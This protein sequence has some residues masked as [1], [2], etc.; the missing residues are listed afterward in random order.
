MDI[1][2][3]HLECKRMNNFVILL[4][5]SYPFYSNTSQIEAT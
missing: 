4:N 5:L 2:N 1:A 3:L